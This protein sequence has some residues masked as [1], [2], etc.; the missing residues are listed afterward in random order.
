MS[1]QKVDTP[2][3]LVQV[4]MGGWQTGGWPPG[5]QPPA[6]HVM[7][8]GQTLPQPPQLLLS[9]DRLVQNDPVG[10]FGHALGDVGGHIVVPPP[11]HIPIWQATPAAQ[12]WPQ[13]PQ[14]AGSTFMSVQYDPPVAFGQLTGAVCGQPTGVEPPHTPPT[15]SRPAAQVAPHWPQLLTSAVTSV[16]NSPAGPKQPLGVVPAQWSDGGPPPQLP[17]WHMTPFGQTLPHWP[18]LAAS[19]VRSVQVI[20]CGP[21][22]CFGSCGGQVVPPP[23]VQ[24]PFWQVVLGGQMF[25]HWP[26]FAPSSARFAQ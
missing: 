7:P 6:L 25:P 11:P 16:Q 22:H 3:G 19:L 4:A 26:Q 17:F 9:I 15:H 20:P 1:A 2:S 5:T 13:P 10:P 24:A 12:A 23:L 14:L 21:G 18:Q 8:F